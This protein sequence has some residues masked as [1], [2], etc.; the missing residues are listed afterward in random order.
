MEPDGDLPCGPVEADPLDDGLYRLDL[1]GMI[2]L[3]PLGGIKDSA[4]RLP[5]PPQDHSSIA[6]AGSDLP[7]HTAQPLRCAFRHT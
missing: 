3:P 2:H 4:L 7:G 6:P 1:S 5:D